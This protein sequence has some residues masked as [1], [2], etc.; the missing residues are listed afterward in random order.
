MKRIRSAIGGLRDGFLPSDLADELAQY[1]TADDLPQRVLTS[2]EESLRSRVQE[3]DVLKVVEAEHA[4]LAHEW[5]NVERRLY[6]APGEEILS[7]VFRHFGATFEKAHDAPRIAQKM[8][9]N[10]LDAEMKALLSRINLLVD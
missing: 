6:H 5:T 10:D 9:A 3:L 4:L 8:R 1:V 2:I 7:R